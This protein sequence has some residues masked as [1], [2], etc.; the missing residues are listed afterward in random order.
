MRRNDRDGYR[1]Q[2]S[3]ESRKNVDRTFD[4]LNDAMDFRDIIQKS[5]DNCEDICPIF[6][7][8]LKNGMKHIA[9]TKYGKYQLIIQKPTLKF[10]KTFLTLDSAKKTREELLKVYYHI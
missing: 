1:V 6:V 3:F 8:L 2:F 5:T 4:S 10:N 9:I 7:D